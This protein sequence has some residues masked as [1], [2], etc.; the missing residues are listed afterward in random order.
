[1]SIVT[2]TTPFDVPGN[3]SALITETCKVNL[4]VK[5]FVGRRIQYGSLVSM[6]G[7]VSVCLSPTWKLSL[8]MC[9]RAWHTGKSCSF[10]YVCIFISFL[11]FKVMIGMSIFTLLKRLPN[12]YGL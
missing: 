12:S 5:V 3:W 4:Q 11:D 2:I 1:M 6:H 7:R 9:G 10:S 8:G